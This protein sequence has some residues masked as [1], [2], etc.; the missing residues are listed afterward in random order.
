MI[1]FLTSFTLIRYRFNF[2]L[3]NCVVLK[4]VVRRKRSSI[5]A[6]IPPRAATHCRRR[7]RSGTDGD[8]ADFLAGRIIGFFYLFLF[9]SGIACITEPLEWIGFLFFF[10][11]LFLSSLFSFSLSS[12]H[13]SSPLLLSPLSFLVL[14]RLFHSPISFPFLPLPLSLFHSSYLPSPPFSLFPSFLPFRLNSISLS[15]LFPSSLLILSFS[16]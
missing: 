1:F 7:S 5:G 2:A 15:Y 4:K 3:G 12:L 10:S 8:N 13:F 6:R 11:F 14:S 16:M 9:L